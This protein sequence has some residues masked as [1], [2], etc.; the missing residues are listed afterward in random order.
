MNFC[1]GKPFPARNDFFNLGNDFEERAAHIDLTV[2]K[3]RGR[4]LCKQGTVLTLQRIIIYFHKMY[5]I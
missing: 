5:L 3:R 1:F 2:G 4:Y